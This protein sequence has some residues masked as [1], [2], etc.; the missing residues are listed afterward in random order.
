MVMAVR[1]N[2]GR[3]IMRTRLMLGVIILV[4]LLLVVRLYF[5]QIIHG[6][7]YRAQATGQYVSA[8]GGFYDRGSIFLKIKMG[9]K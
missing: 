4:A 1:Q 9:E 2:R 5:L 7:E 3:F 8:S 6:S